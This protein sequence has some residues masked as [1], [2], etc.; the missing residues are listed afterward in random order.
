VSSMTI[1]R[2]NNLFWL[3]LVALIIAFLSLVF[4]APAEKILGEAIRYVY[5]HVALTKA[6]MWGLYLSG[7]LG[8]L[9][10]ITGRSKLQS[11]TQLVAWVSFA[12]FLAGGIVS[13]FAGY[14][15]WGGFPLDEPRNRAMFSVIAMTLIVLIANNWLPWIRV[16][17]FLYVL[18]AG[19]VLWIIPN[20]PL[21]LHPGDAGGTSPSATIRWVFL[22]LPL[23]AFLIGAW[24][25]WFFGQRIGDRRKE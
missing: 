4:L 1:H 8:V 15:S 12:L 10:L 7:L 13:V 21:V 19:Y 2:R 3:F 11:W 18:L 5:V 22:L 24:F 17:G 6:G 14:A 16:R 23:L 9:I 25:V 20:T